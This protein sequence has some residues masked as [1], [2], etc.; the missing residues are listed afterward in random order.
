MYDVIIIG[1]GCAGMTAALYALRA[2]KS[3]LLL[4]GN[5]IGGQIASSPR[6]ENIPSI[7]EISGYDYAD[8]L[9]EQVSEHGVDFELET[10]TAVEKRGERDFLV[11]TDYGTHEGRSVIIATGVKH[12]HLGLEGE[13]TLRGVSY[14]AVCDGAFYKGQEVALVGDGNSALQYALLL[15]NYCTKVHMYTMF[16]KFFGDKVL[17]DALQKRD[18]VEI[19]QNVVAVELIGENEL[20]AVRFR[21][22]N[23]T[24]TFVKE[25]PAIFIAI[26][27]IPENEVF[28]GLLELS[29]DGYVKAADD[30]KTSVDGIWAAGDCRTKK[31]RQLTTAAADGAISALSACDYLR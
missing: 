18:N 1:A 5:S 10:V 3:V 12:R 8:K 13:D 23:G 30:C 4:E 7:M 21:E 2:G 20:K 19:T 14:C 25:V 27:Q 29:P 6:V 16:D 11:T 15:S 31:I 24:A 22:T 9:F 28:R 17:V 26:G